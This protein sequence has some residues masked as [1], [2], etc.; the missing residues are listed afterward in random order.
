MGKENMSEQHRSNKAVLLCYVIMDLILV[1]SYLIELIK[2][3]RT[4]G[5]F[6]IF[7]IH[8]QHLHEWSN[9]L[10]KSP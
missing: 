1:A 5:Y 3:N 7:L 6:I 2:G 4:L 9:N 10:K 8:F